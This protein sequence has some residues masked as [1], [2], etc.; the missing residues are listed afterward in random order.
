MGPAT[1]RRRRLSERLSLGGRENQ[2]GGVRHHCYLRWRHSDEIAIGLNRRTVRLPDLDMLGGQDAIA[3]HPVQE[4]EKQRKSVGRDIQST[5][6]LEQAYVQNR[7]VHPRLRRA[8]KPAAIETGVRDDH[9]SS[10]VADAIN[11]HLEAR[12]VASEEL[13]KAGQDVSALAQDSLEWRRDGGHDEG[14]EPHARHQQEFPAIDIAKA[15]PD[16]LPLGQSFWR[17]RRIAN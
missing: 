1:P 10:F 3:R 11:K 9:R 13:R 14:V 7:T 2:P 15:D 17:S 6:P 12:K 8:D 5:M 4:A 16:A